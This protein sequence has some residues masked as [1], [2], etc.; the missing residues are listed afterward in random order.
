MIIMKFGGSSLRST[1]RVQEVSAIIQKYLDQCPVVVLSAMGDTTD[2][3]VEAGKS[4]LQ[5]NHIA[6]RIEE[7]HRNIIAELGL[8]S[9]LVDELLFELSSLLEGIFLIKDLTPKT[10]DTLLSFGERLSVRIVSA[11]LNKL[12]IDRKSVV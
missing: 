11:Y 10:H 3:L 8:Q 2:E 6:P 7:F 9:T 1:K 5:Q 4:A 12:K